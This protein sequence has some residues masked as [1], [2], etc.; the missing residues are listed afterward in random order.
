MTDHDSVEPPAA[1]E[2]RVV[3]TLRARGLLRGGA[4]SARVRRLAP[5]WAWPAAIAAGLLL[6]VG[7]FALGRRP[8]ASTLGA[9]QYTLLLYEGPEFN[10]SG[11]A[12]PDLVN[13][14]SAWAGKLAARGQLVAGEKLGSQAWT[15]GSNGGAA[16]AGPA[17][18]FVIAVRDQSEALAIART[19]PHLRH[20]GTVSVRPI[21]PT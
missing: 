9:Q 13:E 3:G 21:E 8:A 4:G 7:G 2:E 14:Y 6:F 11:V 20:G 12:E 5:R 18:F 17:G 19:C 1:L 15:L 10:P 16:P